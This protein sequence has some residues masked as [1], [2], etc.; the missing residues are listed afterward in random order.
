MTQKISEIHEIWYLDDI[1]M[2]LKKAGC[3]NVRCMKQLLPWTCCHSVQW[4]NGAVQVIHVSHSANHL[5]EIYFTHS[6]YFKLA[7]YSAD[8]LVPAM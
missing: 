5:T 8:R 1:K 2:S 6:A 4:V 7:D 3:N